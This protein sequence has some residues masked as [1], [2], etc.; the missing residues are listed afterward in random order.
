V[1]DGGAERSGLRALGIDVDPLLVAGERRER[2]DVL[3]PD[4]PPATDADL[5]ADPLAQ[6]FPVPPPAS[7][8]SARGE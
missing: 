3:L 7:S 5:R 6:S 4:G 8:V 1:L 2:G